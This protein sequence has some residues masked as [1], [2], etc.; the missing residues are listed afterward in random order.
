MSELSFG[1]GA[2]SGVYDIIEEGWPLQ[3]CQA[4]LRNGRWW[5]KGHIRFTNMWYNDTSYS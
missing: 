5:S 4:A 2:L 1:A 3:A